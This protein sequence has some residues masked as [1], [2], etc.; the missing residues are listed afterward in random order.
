VSTGD[1]ST[2]QMLPEPEKRKLAWHRGTVD[3]GQPPAPA[4]PPF[5]VPLTY[6]E[7]RQDQEGPRPRGRSAWAPV[8]EGPGSRDGREA[9]DATNDDRRDAGRADRERRG[10]RGY[11]NDHPGKSWAPRHRDDSDDFDEGHGRGGRPDHRLRDARGV[12]DEPV[13]RERERSPHRRGWGGNRSG[14]SRRA[15]SPGAQRREDDGT[16]PA[17][18]LQRQKEEE[19]RLLFTLKACS[20]QEVIQNLMTERT[21]DKDQL[22]LDHLMN[23]FLAKASILTDKLQL[24]PQPL[25][26]LLCRGDEALSATDSFFS[27]V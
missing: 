4:F 22:Q 9:K 5:N 23:N 1:G 11:N 18:H 16:P 13:Y 27:N 25:S 6:H 8:Q 21:R 10:G 3:G 12:A 24:A 26:P 7:R 19:L 15:A 2:G 14:G 17:H 20:F